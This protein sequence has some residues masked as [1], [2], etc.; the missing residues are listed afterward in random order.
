MG[1]TLTTM[2]PTLIQDEI[3]PALKLGLIPLSAFSVKAVADRP[4]FKGASVNVPVITAKTAG[5]WSS[6]WATGDTTVVGTAVTI[7]APTFC[8][9]HINPVEEEPTV[10]RFLAEGKEAAYAVA[11]MVLAGVLAKFVAANIG[12]GAG[13]KT[14]VTAANYDV[15]DIADHVGLL[16]AKGVNGPVSAIH[17]LAYS[18]ALMKDPAIQDASAY[19][20]NQLIATGNLPPVLGCTNYYTDAF[21][22]AVTNENTGVIF[23]GKTTTAVAIGAPGE[24]IAGG[25]AQAGIRSITV[26]DPETGLALTWR[27]WVDGNT[28]LHWGS[29][30]VMYGVSFVQNAAVRITSA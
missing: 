15:D 28:G 24:G 4:L 22:T 25:D 30:Y 18:T 11:K 3:L 23:T 6:T 12:S 8:S 17:N 5:S 10:A 21:P 27:T 9:W 1:N 29:V 14:T 26:N 13:D 16:R 19:G 2:S 7:G 20:S